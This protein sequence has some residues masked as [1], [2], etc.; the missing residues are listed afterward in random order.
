M[1]TFLSVLSESP[2]S[3]HAFTVSGITMA[4]AEKFNV[5]LTCG[6]APES[7]IALTL[8]VDFVQKKIFRRACV[9]GSMTEME[10]TQNFTGTVANPIERYH[11]FKIYILVGDD[12]FHVSINDEKFCTF[13]FKMPVKNVKTLL[14]TGD[15]EAVTQADHRIVFPVVYPLVSHDHEDLVFKGLI[16]RHFSPGHVVV[17][18]G[19]LTGNP[20][21]EF[22]IMFNENDSSRQMIH[23]NPRLDEKTVVLNTMNDV[24]E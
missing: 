22:T 3:G 13:A 24:D 18:T 19:E 6:K 1:L 23:F 14:V 11:F 9:N 17:I 8:T 7:D 4:N 20:D 2:T 21:G 10:S 16:P 15:L 12:R 5:A